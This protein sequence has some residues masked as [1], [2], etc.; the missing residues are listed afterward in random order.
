ML[1]SRPL[2]ANSTLHWDFSGPWAQPHTGM[3][4]ELDVT[5]FNEAITI[6]QAPPEIM[7]ATGPDLP[8][9]SH[10]AISRNAAIEGARR[11]KERKLVEPPTFQDDTVDQAYVQFMTTAESLLTNRQ[12]DVDYHKAA[13]H[14]GWPLE[15]RQVALQPTRPTGWLAKP[16]GF[17][18]WAALD[19]RF[20]S[21]TAAIAKGLGPRAAQEKERLVEQLRKV[22]G[23]SRILDKGVVETQVL[24]LALHYATVES[25]A[26]GAMREFSRKSLRPLLRRLESHLLRVRSRGFRACIANSLKLGAGALHRHTK[27]WDQPIQRLA[28]SD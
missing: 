24:D 4:A 9:E 1:V 2:A 20:Q 17:A 26:L 14:R 12:A 23:S 5:S 19:V 10:Q 7:M 13:M 25:P 15:V 3:W 18:A 28:E 16:S 8:W 21:Y 22:R 6:F 27:T 11:L